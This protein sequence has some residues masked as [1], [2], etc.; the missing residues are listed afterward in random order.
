MMPIF[1]I[2]SQAIIARH[3]FVLPSEAI[4]AST[5]YMYGSIIKVEDEILH[6]HNA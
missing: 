2:I 1:A 5:S 4:L 3:P 6:M